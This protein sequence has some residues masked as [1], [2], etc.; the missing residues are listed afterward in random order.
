[1]DKFSQNARLWYFT[2]LLHGVLWTGLLLISEGKFSLEILAAPLLITVF[3]AITSAIAI[4]C[5]VPLFAYA[6]PLARRQRLIAV[7]IIILLLWGLSTLPLIAIPSYVR[8]TPYTFL[9]HTLPGLGA[10]YLATAYVYRF[11]LFRP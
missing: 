2:S 1:M 6:L 9:S 7:G 8:Y 11:R 3:G 4:P 10:A 5:A